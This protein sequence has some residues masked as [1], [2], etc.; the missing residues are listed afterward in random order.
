MKERSITKEKMET[1]S[2]AGG[3]SS[4]VESRE[5]LRAQPS[6]AEEKI[7]KAKI[8][9]IL[10]VFFCYFIAKFIVNS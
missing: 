8:K 1:Q 9:V 10:I 7:C 6:A 5:V 4:A 2:T 3:E